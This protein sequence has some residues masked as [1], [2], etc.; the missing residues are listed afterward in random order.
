AH[1]RAAHPHVL[2]KF[3]KCRWTLRIEMVQNAGLVFAQIPPGLVTAHMATVTRK[4]D[5]RI[6]IKQPSCSLFHDSHQRLRKCLNRQT[7][8]ACSWGFEHATSSGPSHNYDVLVAV[9]P[10]DSESAQRVP[11]ACSADAGFN[12][13]WNTFAMKKVERPTPVLVASLDHG[14]DRLSNAA[15]GFD[16]CIPQIIEP[17]QDIVM[18]K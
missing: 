17:A 18:P 9:P 8:L 10:Q 14:F 2:G 6:S 15:V 12:L 5:C 1:R 16:S 4:I 11:A 13:Q 3:R 7:K